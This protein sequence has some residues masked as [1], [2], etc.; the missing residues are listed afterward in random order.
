MIKFEYITFAL[1][2]YSI[3]CIIHHVLTSYGTAR[4]QNLIQ[5]VDPLD[6]AP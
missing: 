6:L 1:N 3:N 4:K 5:P 2:K